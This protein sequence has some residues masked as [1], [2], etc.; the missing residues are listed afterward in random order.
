MRLHSQG[1][2]MFIFFCTISVFI[3]AWS[4]NACLYSFQVAVFIFLWSNSVFIFFWGGVC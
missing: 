1:V 3:F 4:S 2:I